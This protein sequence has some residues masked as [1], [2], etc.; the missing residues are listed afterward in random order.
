M[1]KAN[2]GLWISLSLFADRLC[3]KDEDKIGS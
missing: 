2:A 3:L 1:N